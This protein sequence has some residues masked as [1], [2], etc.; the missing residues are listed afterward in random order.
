MI[1][2]IPD[3]QKKNFFL[4]IKGNATIE[5]AAE[6]QKIFIKAADQKNLI[7]KII[8]LDN[9]DATFL[10]LLAALIEAFQGG[11]SKSLSFDKWSLSILRDCLKKFGYLKHSLFLP[12]INHKGVKDEK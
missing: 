8:K 4:N 1:E 3:E 5:E 11:Q 9:Y 6:Y 2:L 12:Y 10:Q 7:I